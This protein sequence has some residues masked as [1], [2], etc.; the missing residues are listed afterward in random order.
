MIGIVHSVWSPKVRNPVAKGPKSG[1]QKYEAWSPDVRSGRPKN[2]SFER[3]GQRRYACAVTALL[4]PERHPVRDFFVLDALDVAPRSDMATMAHPIFSL[5]PRP[6]MRTLRYAQGDT[7]VEILPSSKGLASIFDKDIL[8]YCI[9]KLMYAKNRGETIGQVVRITTHDLLVATNRHTG[10]I[11]YARIENALDRLAGTRIKTNIK[12]G[13]ETSTQNFGL[14]EWYD[15]NRKGSGFADRLRYLDIKLSD[16]LFR[17]M[18]AKEV[19]AISR[20]YFLLRRPLDRRIYEIARK[21]CGA[22]STW[23]IAIDKLQARTGSKQAR[24]HF[25][26]HLRGLVQSNHLPDYTM[27]IENDQAV[28]W[29]R[30]D[31]PARAMTVVVPEAAAARTPRR[32]NVSQSA[33]DQLYDFAP[34]WD[35][36]MLVAAYIEWAKDKDAAR[37]EDARFIGW[38]KSYTKGKAAP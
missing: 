11:V 33:I 35:K 20:D 18:Q 26:A 7:I 8:I 34:G 15:Y 30:A 14:I 38:A 37:S 31:R 24:K 29:R 9:S 13:D 36:Y 23:R 22:Q 12:T 17:A 3:D 16:W 32:V 27:V 5:S 28:F 2:E 6:E 1:R 19:L 21:H 10:G 25:A 4:L